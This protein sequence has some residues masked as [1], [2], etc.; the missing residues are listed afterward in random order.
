MQLTVSLTLEQPPTH[1]LSGNLSSNS[2]AGHFFQLS[3]SS[4]SSLM[5]G[6]FGPLTGGNIYF[7]MLCGCVAYSSLRQVLF[8]RDSE[9]DFGAQD[10]MESRFS[11]SFVPS[12]FPFVAMDR[13]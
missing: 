3:S 5:G 10:R 4:M 12:G 6:V 1:E 9:P 8:T 13:G 2:G 11:F 7:C